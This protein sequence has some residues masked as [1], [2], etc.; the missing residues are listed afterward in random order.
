MFTKE[1][2]KGIRLVSS[3]IKVE[4]PTKV[5]RFGLG[6]KSVFHLTDLPSILSGSQIGIIDPHGVY[7]SDRRHRRTGKYW[8]LKEDCSVIADIRDQFLPYNGV[9]D[10]TNDVFS[11]GFYNGTLFRFPLRTK[12]SELSQTL[13][14]PEKMDALFESFKAYPHLMLLFLT[15]VECIELYV[16]EESESKP[17]R[18]FQVKVAD[19]NVMTVRNKRKE[20]REK[21]TQRKLN[22]ESIT[23]TYPITIEVINFD[24]NNNEGVKQHSFL[25]T[26]YFCGE[27]VSSEFKKLITDK[28]L[29]YL[30]TVSVAMP[31]PTDPQ[32]LTPDIQGHV[33]CFL[34]LP[35]QKTTLTGLPV[36]INGFF[37][38]S[39]N[40]CHVK[41]PSAYQ[42]D[43]ERA[44]RVLTDKALLWN[45][46]LLGE[47]L[48]RAYVKMIMAAINMR[49][50]NIPLEAIYK[51][52]PDISSIDHK[53]KRL[54]K[55]LFKLLLTEKVIHTRAQ[56][57]K[58]LTVNEAIFHRLPEDREKDL[59]LRVLLSANVP[60]V[61]V[62]SHVLNAIDV[63]G[64][65][66]KELTPYMVRHLLRQVPSSYT[67][68]R[69][70]EKLLL[71]RCCL[72]DRHFSDLYGLQLLPLANGTFAEFGNRATSIFID[73]P[74]H[75]QNLFPA[76]H[77]RFLDKSV[78]EDILDNLK[79]AALQ[80]R[81]QL[82]F[83]N[84]EVV[85]AFLWYGLPSNWK[86]YDTVLWYP[87]DSNRNHPPREWIKDLW[88]YLQKHF[89]SK[90]SIVTLCK[91]PLIPLS[92]SQTPIALA[93]LCYPSRV[94]VKCLN[95]DCLSD[96]LTNVLRKLGLIIMSEFPTFISQHPAV[97]G[98]VV[99]P[100]SVQGVL[101]AMVVSSSKVAVGKLVEILQREVSPEGKQLLRSF[102]AN[103]RPSS[104]RNEEFYLLH[105]LPVF[106]T[107][108]KKFVSAGDGLYAAP[109]EPLPVAPRHELIDASQDDSK[110]LARFLE[111]KSLTPTELLCQMVFP[112][113]KQGKYSEKQ[114][115]QLMAYVLERF[116][117]DVH[118]NPTF[119]QSLQALS[120]VSKHRGRVRPL[121]VFDPRSDIL[122]KIFVGQ[123]I[124]PAGALYTTPAVLVVLEELGMKSE[125]NIT[126]NG[127]YQSAKVVTMLTRHSTA[128]QKSKAILQYLDDNP[129]KLQ[130]PINGQPLGRLLNSCQW[131]PRL[132]KVPPNYPQS[133]PWWETGD[134]E[135]RYFFRPDE[136]KSHQLVNLIGSVMPVVEVEPSNEVSKYFGWQ[137]QPDVVDV[138]KQFKTVTRCYSKEEKP[139]YMVMVDEIY[140]FLNHAKYAAVAQA[141]ASIEVTD[142]IWNGDGFSSPN[143]VLSSKPLIDLTPYICS[144]PSEMMKHSDLFH[145]FGMREESDPAV[146]V[147]VLG[148]IKEKHDNRSVQFSAS[149]VEHD[150]QLTVNILNVMVSKELSTELQAKIL[151][152]IHIE[153]NSHVKLEPVEH[154]MYCEREWLKRGDD[155][156]VD[157]FYV[158]P[159]VPNIVAER[160]GVPTLTNRMLDADELS[161]GEEFGQEEKLTTRL[162]QLLEEYT[163]G[164]AVL[165]ELIQNAD[166]AGGTEVRFLYDE[167]TNEDALTCLFN[168]GMRHCQGPALWVYNDA[169]FKDEDF[170]NITKLNEATKVHNTE[171]IGRFGLGFNS[172]YNLTD[173]PM[174]LSQN[175]FV[176]LDPHMSYLGKAVRNK[177]KPG[178]KIDVNKDVK[179]LRK[180]SNQFKPFNG[181]FGCDLHL[182]KDDNSFDGTLFRFPL[183]T[184]EQAMKSEIKK[185]CYDDQEM[186][187]LLQML[188]H[189]A[190]SLLLF[191]QNVFRVGIY[192]L[193]KLS[194]QD[195]KPLLMFEV[196][197]S[198]PQGGTLREMS[199]PITLPVAAEKL[200]VAQQS[201]LKQFNF[202]QASSKFTRDSRDPNK[203]PE[204]NPSK[205]PETSIRVDIHCT[206]TR[207]GVNFFDVGK[208]FG[209]ERVTWLIVSSM[210]NGQ[211]VQFARNDVNCVPSGGVAVQLV[212]TR[213]NKFLPLPVVEE[214]EEP[215]H[216]GTIFCYLPL[217]IHSGLPLHINGAFAVAANR[218]CLQEKL[219]DDKN[220]QGADWNNVLMQDTIVSAYFG[221][222]ED[223]KSFA[224]DDGSYKFHSL[225]PKVDKVHRGCSPILT[226]FYT[227]LASGD[228]ALFSDGRVWVDIGRVVFLD[229]KFRMEPQVG[230]ASFA[231]FK[232]LAAENEV[233][234]DLPA[235]VFQSFIACGLWDVIKTRIYDK[236]RFFRELFFPN[237]LQVRSDLR[238]VLV[239]HV[240]DNS[241][242]DFDD[243]IMRHACIPASPS[244]STLKCPGQLV[245]PNREASS[246]FCAADG[247]F[248]FGSNDTFCNPQRLAKLEQ[249]GM[250]SNCLPW[251]EI[252]ERAES[253]GRVNEVDSKAAV[254]R[255][256]VLIPFIEAKMKSDDKGPSNSICAR[257]L[258]AKFLPVLQRPKNF[259]L[260]WKGD[261][262][263]GRRKFLLAPK[264]AF[265]KE[266][267]N[268][269]CCTEPLVAFDVSKNVKELLK[270]ERQDVT[271]NHVLKQLED[272][273]ASNIDSLNR[274]SYDEVKR[275]CLAAYSFF[276]KAMAR[277]HQ[278]VKEVLL[279]KRFILIGRRFLSA[280]RVA[281]EMKKDCSPYL[282]KL[283]EDL[284]DAFWKVMKHAGVKEQFE[285]KD[286][287][288]S[289]QQ[290]KKQFREM[291][292]DKKT[293]EV[294]VNLAI[295][296]GETLEKSSGD[297]SSHWGP[298]YL[299][300]SRDVMRPVPELC[301]KDCPWMPDDR[302]VHFV[303]EKIPWPTC[304]GLGVKTRRQ[305]ALQNHE[306]GIPFGQREKLTNRLKRILTAYPC[307]KELL[308]ELLQNADDAEATEI[309]FIQDPRHHADEKVFEDSWK[310]L[311]GPA[312]CVYNN[313]PFTEADIKGVQNLGEGSKGDDSNTTG[314]YGVGFNAVY[315]L[316][317]VP[318]FRSRSDE[319]GDVLCVFDPNCRYV[320]NA[321][322]KE[323]GRM[324]RDIKMLK[325]K[326]PDVFPCY[327]EDHFPMRNATIFRFPLRSEKMAEVSNISS[328]PVTVKKLN[329]MMEDLK[330]ELFEVLLFLN[331]VKRISLCT[332][333]EPSGNV[334][335]TYSVEVLMSHED[336]EK[337][338]AFADCIKELGIQ[339]KEK[340]NFLPTSINVTKCSYIM[341][342]R[343]N[344]GR[345]EK[346]FVVQRVGFETSVEDSIVDA[347]KEHQLVLL[348]RGGVACLLESKSPSKKEKTSKLKQAGK[349]EQAR[350]SRKKK[351]YCFLP[352][353]FE[354][355][356]PVHINGHFALD[357][358]ARRSLWR[359]EAGGYKSDWNTAL[360]SDVIALCYLTLLEEVRGFLQLPMMQDYTTPGSPSCS[361][362]TIFKRLRAYEEYF[363]K[364]SAKD[365]HCKILVEAVYKGMSNKEM[366]LIPSVK[367]STCGVRDSAEVT[368][369]PPTGTGKDKTYFS[370]LKKEGCFAAP[371]QRGEPESN[372]D[373]ENKSRR[374]EEKSRFVE[375]LIETGFNLVA[376][377]V[378]IFNSLRKAGVDVCCIAPSAVMD[379][380]KSFSDPDSLCNIGQIPC[381][382]DKTPFKNSKRV[383][384]VLKYCKDAERFVEN[385]EG[386]PLLLTQDNFLRTFSTSK[387]R[388]L[389]HYTDILPYSPSIFVHNELHENI[390]EDVD[391]G[392]A[393]VFRPLDVEIFASYL[394]ETLPP[395]FYGEDVFV[396]WRPDNPPT[397]LPNRCWIN[398]VWRFLQEIGRDAVRR[399][400]ESEE[401]KS[402]ITQLLSPL[403]GWCL[404]PATKTT[405]GG[406]PHN[407]CT[408]KTLDNTQTVLEHVLVPLD[409]AKCVVDL[410]ESGIP[411]PKLIEIL[412]SLGLPELNLDVLTSTTSPFQKDSYDFVRNLVAT[413]KSP[414]FLL[415]ALDQKLE[416]N[417]RSPEDKLKSSDFLKVL[418]YFSDNRQSL[419]DVHREPLRQLPFYTTASGG[420]ARLESR[421]GYILPEEFPTLD[422]NVVES[423]LGCL[424]LK[425]HPSLTGLYEFLEVKRVSC[426]EAYRKFVLKCFQYF[427]QEGRLVHL[428][429][430]RQ[431]VFLTGGEKRKRDVD[432]ERLLHHLKT[433]EFIPTKDGKLMTASSFYDPRNDVFKLLLTDDK[434]PPESFA[435]DE[436]LSF[437]KEIGLVHTVSSDHFQRFAKQVAHEAATAQTENTRKKSEVL[438]KHLFSRKNVLNGGLLQI[439]CGIP[440]VAADPVRRPLQ[441]I[442]P[443]FVKE[444]DG[445]TPF[446]AYKGSVCS[447]HEDVVWTK[448]PLLPKWADPTCNRDKLGCPPDIHIVDHCKCFVAQLQI[449]EDP[450]VDV[451][452]DHCITIC[453]QL[454]SNSKRESV[455]PEQCHTIMG[456]MERIYTFLQRNAIK[457]S[458]LKKRLQTACCI[459]VEGGKKFVLPRQAVL[460]LYEDLEI[461]PYLYRVPPEFGKFQLLFEYLGCS[462]S[463]R[464][465]HYAMVLA[466]LHKNCLNVKLHPNEVSLCCKAVKGFFERLQ[467]H[468]EEGATI[469]KL[470][471]P[472]VCPG[473]GSSPNSPLNT[474][475]VTLQKSADLIFVDQPAY[476]SRIRGLTQPCVLE[477]SMMDISCK[478][479]MMNYKELM[480]KLPEGVQPRMLS[481][482]VKEQLS[483]P[484]NTETVTDGTVNI[485][486]QQ[487]SSGQFGCG[488]ARLIRDVNSQEEDFDEEVIA[489]I[490]CSLRSIDLCAVKNLKTSLFYN[491]NFIPGSEAEV[492]F[493]QQRLLVSGK[494]MWRVYINAVT[495]MDEPFSAVSLVSNVIAEMYGEL[496]GKKAVLIPEMLRCPLSKIW[497]LLDN[498]G[499]RQD[500]TYKAVEMDIFPEPGS[501]IPIEDHHLL[502]DAFEEFEPEEYVGYQ[503]D[504]PSL[505]LED[506]VATY[507]YAVIIEEMINEDSEHL[508]TKMYRINIGHNKE[509]VVV[510]ADLYKFHRVKEISDQQT[511]RSTNET[512]QVV[513]SEI[514]DLLEDA[515]RQEE[516]QRRQIVKRLFLRWHPDKNKGNEEF[517]TQVFQHI[518]SEICRLG[519]VYDDFFVSWGARAR[520]HGSQ[521]EEYRMRFSQQYGSWG[522]TTDQ[523]SWHNVPPSFCKVNSQPGE[524]RRWF[525]QAEADLV[526]GADEIAFNKPSYEWACF[527]CHQAAEKALKAAQ[528]MVDAKK[529][530]I[531]NLVENSLSL[532]D[533]D[534]TDL[535]GQLESLI[536]DS[537]RMRYPDSMCYPHIPHDVYSAQ[538]AQEAL[539]I[540]KKIVERVRGRVFSGATTSEK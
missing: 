227:Q 321:S 102:L 422:L 142:W 183:R 229:P 449:V 168:E 365:P 348:P 135:E 504:D 165:K 529:M 179:N 450:S 98:S 64:S 429:Y 265:L 267:K 457:N 522:G 297:P 53:W 349:G 302:G 525:R 111:V 251:K 89:V 40:R 103:V 84:E 291:P 402:V 311:Q 410:A 78:D 9:F 232:K 406:G 197:K 399:P 502:N 92:M 463:V 248:P 421:K 510:A 261:E 290:V 189:K 36:H 524:A 73:S 301:M 374:N 273:I 13:C 477:L 382:V 12:P 242:S 33:F 452:V 122:R 386:L 530:N 99:N 20:F 468:P 512:R 222:L 19:D 501:F 16:R 322:D 96:A 354:T 413:L 65:C 279:D 363:P 390:F 420:T 214:P 310:P 245:N 215:N 523:K 494:E 196:C 134:T 59:L 378:D 445:I 342:L 271:V 442:C 130:E 250:A 448:A 173:V 146:L 281:L 170:V 110:S 153:G 24:S 475:P 180:F 217:P 66:R 309:C 144:L 338:Q 69:R 269:V 513:F 415:M 318:S 298:V 403:S 391:C 423:R 158:H 388:C 97:L 127:L 10:C 112:D 7:F 152:P 167:R 326:F 353:P 434:F 327:L 350:A 446:I 213:S 437:L 147:Q 220:C 305:E 412:R 37:A 462:R 252:A 95:D 45:N 208:C 32:Q 344:C 116:A 337:R 535:A 161:I 460:E 444:K 74:E 259:P 55:P 31:L 81:T 206:L 160:L 440:F 201:F 396:E 46:C 169:V 370:N 198:I 75:P 296:L 325:Q 320:P 455:S 419:T 424:F 230:D 22:S 186:R 204:G 364:Y 272:A 150:L 157:Y 427:S 377:S 264:D 379:F 185:L 155:E 159:I 25:V 79:A 266:K 139:F 105:S 101:K 324:F 181:I 497:S 489:N 411:S 47:A 125:H 262:F 113:I 91:L 268:L 389:S 239:L 241:R 484:E 203:Y 515:W 212:P 469:S 283:P 490:E 376:F 319:I 27:E 254:K 430:I 280:N 148:M 121:D 162:S 86:R 435:S 381:S 260:T 333:D 224:P 505:H 191:T 359:D 439:V 209:Q 313:S 467:E 330:K 519:S 533:P 483:N 234:I 108:S 347:F 317:D 71:L 63:Y 154:C 473:H 451:V 109:D 238:D 88:R 346:W 454:Q 258:E 14:F 192:T 5:G 175:Y 1:D 509:P 498:M 425:S 164:F 331:N 4:D 199:F 235:D 304:D 428:G 405:Q 315:H 149:E 270:F 481:S 176:I 314:Q 516:V 478:S 6:F 362:G 441:E 80:G 249:L 83:L 129:Q 536:G 52:W 447:D 500:D 275:I 373:Q 465:A 115:D 471:L 287:I 44:G 136:V 218:R 15:H 171:K 431:L 233:V 132:Q 289:L 300:D 453:S 375:T 57:G 56:S 480:M 486:R 195:P 123:N 417:L 345:E 299:P 277:N 339:A 511:Q 177:G 507:I 401:S 70:K 323:P 77:H 400:E 384:R 531:H 62:P 30:P 307:E 508:P 51:A 131:V 385:L 461:K 211:A 263:Q 68:L 202:L 256:E 459:L 496:L 221:L 138:V 50:F 491:G 443:P 228:Y 274:N 303:N 328:A 187:E 231:I 356:L 128:V 114:I 316:T 464:P 58:W 416:M 282:Y 255:V 414:T 26:N 383:I 243:L 219:A 178:M 118:R 76:L 137:N 18:I 8:N 42:V 366:R 341:T 39:Q 140:S 100:P 48:P 355:D 226:S 246:L 380:Y 408:L 409:K 156:D 527:K 120:F 106:E 357:H 398:K 104:L 28:E 528:Y 493:F 240:L 343:D 200:N 82:R 11:Q 174:L 294:S 488:I 472:A 34:P 295:Q 284:A 458:V 223:L 332:I 358:E 172:V 182:D 479:A 278:Q 61:T 392:N 126:G 54:E 67:N 368:W 293:K 119:K 85:A 395:N 538:M 17:R 72:R 495:E 476:V 361:K 540:A 190:H 499:I 367:S 35:V 292:L 124:F 526:A 285:E 107:L 2:W 90:E 514:S 205:S 436:W 329:V 474:I 404:L 418:E 308:K 352:L 506:G 397:I 470:Y 534:L 432:E 253:I 38:L 456:V 532:S 340:D 335:N 210:G 216:S 247:R 87:D 43:E 276:Q 41:M 23:V 225:W 184:R 288:S 60:V 21:I 360:L 336:D 244:G 236:S 537:A 93:R 166:D 539:G 466:M 351:V 141:F 188:L 393:S 485:L 521:R 94:V 29:S 518:Q 145:H 369:F 426:V 257:L 503:L 433:V 49:P 286:Y 334:V 520:E 487:I 492:P 133:L 517:C 312:L 151:L 482:V 306:V 143:H 371:C 194:T 407:S 237:I 207:V 387:P 394:Y 372:D 117:S 3:S 438:V 193:S 163:D